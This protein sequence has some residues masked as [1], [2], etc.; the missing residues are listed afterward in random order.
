MFLSVSLGLL[1]LPGRTEAA[2]D[3]KCEVSESG[4]GGD[5]DGFSIMM[6]ALS[7]I[8]E[9]GFIFDLANQVAG[10][11]PIELVCSHSEF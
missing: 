11:K 4:G 7:N 2:I 1:F 8:P 5:Y 6:G 10:E 3:A 9:I